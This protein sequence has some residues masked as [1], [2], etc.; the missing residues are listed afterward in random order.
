MVRVCENT[1]IFLCVRPSVRLSYVH[2]SVILYPPKPLN[3][4][5]LATSLPFMVRVCESNISYP[6]VRRPVICPSSYLLLNHLA[7]FN[8]YMTSRHGKGVR[9]QHYFSVR[10]SSICLSRYLLLN[11]RVIF[12]QTCCIIT[13][14]D[15]GL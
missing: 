13:P 3:S 11:Y 2:L 15:K 8:F 10:P 9:E 14:Y 12:N 6:C 5:K 7:E 1:I 4:T